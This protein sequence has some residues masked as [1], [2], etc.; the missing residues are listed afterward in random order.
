MGGS[1]SNAASV[2]TWLYTEEM[3]VWTLERG[4]P[5]RAKRSYPR[6]RGLAVAWWRDPRVVSRNRVL[7]A[8]HVEL[9]H[10]FFPPGNKGVGYRTTTKWC[11]HKHGIAIVLGLSV[12][13]NSEQQ[14]QTALFKIISQ[15]SRQ[16][17]S[18]KKITSQQYFQPANRLII[19]VELGSTISVQNH[20]RVPD[21]EREASI[22]CRGVAVQSVKLQLRRPNVS[23]THRQLYSSSLR[24]QRINKVYYFIITRCIYPNV[25]YYILE[26]TLYPLHNVCWSIL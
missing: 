10:A 7:M 5:L 16:C 3:G 23:A 24:S 20:V 13:V 14:N 11:G 4:L 22:R 18:L 15:I 2:S 12:I 1:S 21:R 8:V 26:K 19:F 25:S 6:R 17:F 9:S